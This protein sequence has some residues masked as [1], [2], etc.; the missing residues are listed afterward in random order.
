MRGQQR[1]GVERLVDRAHGADDVRE[2]EHERLGRSEPLHQPIDRIDGGLAHLRREMGVDLRGPGARVAQ[3]HLDDAKVHSGFQQV[4]G[5]GVP[6]RV[7]VRALVDAALP[8]GPDEADCRLVREIGPA[9]AGT[10]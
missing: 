4:G 7:H 6:Q 2:F 3:I 5:V 9:P 8:E 10:K 1:G